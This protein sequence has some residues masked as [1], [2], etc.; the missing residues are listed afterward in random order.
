LLTK[1]KGLYV[2]LVRALVR[3]LAPWYALQVLTWQQLSGSWQQLTWQ[4]A[5]RFLP[6]GIVY[7]V[8]VYQLIH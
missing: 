7:L 4:H 3:H 6:A 5:P 1:S 8:T 2:Y